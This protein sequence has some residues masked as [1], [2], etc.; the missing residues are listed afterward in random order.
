M[1]TGTLHAS[2]SRTAALVAACSRERSP[3]ARCLEMVR[4]RVTGSPLE[5]TV[6]KTENTVSAT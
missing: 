3:F 5:E 6:R 4:E 2:D 1:V